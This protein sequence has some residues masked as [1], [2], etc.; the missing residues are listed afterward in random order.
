MVAAAKVFIFLRRT[1]SN[2]PFDIADE[3][4]DGR[5]CD[6]CGRSY[7]SGYG[8]ERH[9][10]RRRSLGE[11]IR[12][13]GRYLGCATTAGSEL[14]NVIEEDRPLQIVELR[15]VHGDLGEERIGHED[16]G[17]VA[18]TCIGIAQQSGDVDLK[19]TGE[20]VER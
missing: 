3:P 6:V 1:S 2:G 19:S 20:A 12:L 13:V 9:R 4:N 15:G 7:F 5:V 8:E 17:L 14:A 18:M 10:T 16:R 11:V